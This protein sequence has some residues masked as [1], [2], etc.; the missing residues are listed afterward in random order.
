[1]NIV[2]DRGAVYTQGLGFTWDLGFSGLRNYPAREA[3]ERLTFRNMVAWPASVQ[4]YLT[5][6]RLN[7]FR[8]SL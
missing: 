6:S 7:V 3:Q 4:L 8:L 2:E 1:M 5:L